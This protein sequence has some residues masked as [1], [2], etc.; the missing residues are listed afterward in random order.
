MKK[1]VVYLGVALIAFANVSFASKE[2]P[3]SDI[4][5][6]IVFSQ[7]VTPL[8]VAIRKGDLETV[9]KF[10]EYGVDVN[11]TS[12]GLSPLMIAAR[13]NKTEIIKFLLSKGARL[14]EKDEHGFTALKYAQLSNAKEAIGLL[15]NS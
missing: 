10:V 11:E 8:N 5:N 7:T 13:Y 12:E 4:K 15:K 1:S 9:K 6:R 3:V 14:N 2:R